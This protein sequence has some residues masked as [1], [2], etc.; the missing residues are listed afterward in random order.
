[1]VISKLLCAKDVR[2]APF[3][4]VVARYEVRPYQNKLGIM[5]TPTKTAACH[6]HVQLIC[7]KA[8]EPSF[9]TLQVP[10]KIVPYLTQVHRN[11]LK[12]E[13]NYNL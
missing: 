8:V 13:F 11:H 5:R 12:T 7:I 10:N 6:Y 1:M 9:T 2:V 4:V 3:N